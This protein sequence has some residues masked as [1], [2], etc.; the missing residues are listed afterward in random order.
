MGKLAEELKA[1]AD[2]AFIKNNSPEYVKAYN[3]HTEAA[4]KF[5]EKVRAFRFGEIKDAEF[6]EAKKVYEIAGKVFDAAY[7]K[8]RG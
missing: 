7:D 4:L 3:V 8:E 1:K 2:A 6:I 5:R